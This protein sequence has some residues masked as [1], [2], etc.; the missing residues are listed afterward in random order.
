M[1]FALGG[2]SGAHFNP[3]VTFAV[4]LSGRNKIGIKDA[5]VYMLCQILG[6]ICAACTYMF[7]TGQAFFLKPVWEYSGAD[8]VMVEIMYSWALC[9]VVLNVATTT[10]YPQEVENSYFGLAIGSISG[11]SLNPAVSI[12]SYVAAYR[13]HGEPALAFWALY[14]FAPFAGALIAWLSF[15]MVRRS[16]EYPSGFSSS[17]TLPTTKPIVE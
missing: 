4:L 13:T 12:G 9:Y 8:V 10:F 15:V 17:T 2:V 11:C 6:G 1:I 14:T 16:T 3:A 7:I 5:F